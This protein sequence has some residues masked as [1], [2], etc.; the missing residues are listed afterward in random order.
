MTQRLV[1]Q[2]GTVITGDKELGTFP[3]ADI[4]VEGSLI[5]AVQPGMEVSES[6]VIDASGMMVMPGLVDA[7]RH[8]WEGT[9]KQLAANSDL[10][11]YASRI[12]AKF[13]PVYRPEDAGR[14]SRILRSILMPCFAA[15]RRAGCEPSLATAFLIPGKSGRMKA[16]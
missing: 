3:R 7:H 1:I 11:D 16:H 13:G 9:L 12:L 2:N 10:G 4:L 6:T 8:T 5:R 15:F 14:I